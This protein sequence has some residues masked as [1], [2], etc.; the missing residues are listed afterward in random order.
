[1]ARV[2]ARWKRRGET[3]PLTHHEM[4]IV[5]AL[6]FWLLTV[7]MMIYASRPAA[8][9]AGAGDRPLTKLIKLFA[10][11]SV[12]TMFAELYE[13]PQAIDPTT[14]TLHRVG[15]TSFILRCESRQTKQNPKKIVYALKCRLFPYTGNRELAEAT[16]RYAVT[17]GHA[18]NPYVVHPYESQAKWILMDFI[19]GQSLDQLISAA[20][21]PGSMRHL[22]LGLL[23]TYGIPLLD[24][25]TSISLQREESRE[26]MRHLNLAPAHVMVRSTTLNQEG[27][28][29]RIAL[30][31]FGPNHGLRLVAE[32]ALDAATVTRYK[33]PELL[34]A[35]LAAPPTGLE[36][37]YSLG[38]IL[39][40]LSIHFRTEAGY[41]P[42]ELYMDAPLL[43]RFV[44]DLLDRDPD[45][46][47]LLLPAA[48]R[49][50]GTSSFDPSGVYK[51]L[52]E[53]LSHGLAA[54]EVLATVAPTLKSQHPT[55]QTAGLQWLESTVANIWDSISSVLEFEPIKRPL[56]FRKVARG[57]DAGTRQEF[58]YFFDW[59]LACMFGWAIVWILTSAYI[60]NETLHGTLLPALSE[61][62]QPG[63]PPVSWDSI[64]R[65]YEALTSGRVTGLDNLPGRLVALTFGLAATRYYLEIL[66]MLSVRGVRSAKSRQVVE[67]SMRLNALWFAPIVLVGNL[68]FVRHWLL[69]SAAA[70]V[71]VCANNYLCWRLATQLVDQGRSEF[72]TVRNSDVGQS[73]SAYAE[74]WKLMVMYG[75]MLI[76]IGALTEVGLARDIWVYAVVVIAVNMLKLYRSNCGKLAPAL[77]AALSHAFVTGERLDALERRRTMRL[78]AA[79]LVG[80]PRLATAG[81]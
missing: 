62:I 22:D 64:V 68:F 10:E 66:G 8:T 39:V 41:I 77:R 25:L 48:Q 26:A 17:Y 69:F 56:Q 40:D 3:R 81:R 16:K 14:A 20:K 35:E 53:R 54:H 72:S 12:Q 67:W 47:L 49:T 19:D 38:Q 4:E 63:F 55:L 6:G 28:A 74:W 44:E 27:S 45:K 31:S 7:R 43:G 21:P 29:P 13:P 50:F 61:V 42:K 15:T 76:V 5:G 79:G 11:R 73:I 60:L 33:A 32:A 34:H 18:D 1:V 46:R 52:R 30:I 37:M 71:P 78:T 57:G 70:L 24:A 65:H 2:Y 51:E 59:A 23:R 58:G 80:P 36:D 9:A 75:G